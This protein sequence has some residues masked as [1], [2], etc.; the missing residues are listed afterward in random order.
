MAVVSRASNN[1]R[2]RLFIGMGR[3]RLPLAL[4]GS[5]RG[6]EHALAQKIELGPSVHLPFDE[7]QAMNVSFDW[8]GALGLRECRRYRGLI[9]A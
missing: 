7:L 8:A 5:L 3:R 4:S 9:A 2:T 6:L 1:E